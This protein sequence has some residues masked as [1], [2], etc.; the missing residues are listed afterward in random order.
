[1]SGVSRFVPAMHKT[2]HCG[3]QQVYETESSHERWW[4]QYGPEEEEFLVYRE[5]GE[6]MVSIRY[7]HQIRP[8]FEESS[9]R[10]RMEPGVRTI[11]L[12]AVWRDPRSQRSSY[13]NTVL[14]IDREQIFCG[15]MV[16]LGLA[17]Q[18]K[19]LFM[20]IIASEDDA[21]RA[22]A[23]A[24]FKTLRGF[25]Q[26]LQGDANWEIWSGA[27]RAA[28]ENSLQME[29]ILIAILMWAMYGWNVSRERLFRW[30][31]LGL[32]R[33]LR[34]DPEIRVNMLTPL[35][36]LFGVYLTKNE[37]DGLE[38]AFAQFDALEDFTNERILHIL[39]REILPELL[40][41][42]ASILASLESGR[43]RFYALREPIRLKDG[44]MVP[45]ERVLP[46]GLRVLH[47]ELTPDG[48]QIRLQVEE[49]NHYIP[50][51]FEI[52]RTGRIRVVVSGQPLP[53]TAVNHFGA[54]LLVRSFPRFPTNNRDF[55]GVRGVSLAG[56]KGDGRERPSALFPRPV[57][58]EGSTTIVKL[59]TII[60]DR[61]GYEVSSP[62]WDGGRIP[63]A[64]NDSD[65]IGCLFIKGIKN[66]S[67]QISV[68]ETTS[69]ASLQTRALASSF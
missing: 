7:H 17:R 65:R 37:E 30:V 43:P 19:T 27:M 44:S 61:K 57:A 50:V 38:R 52:P 6:E 26:E 5:R 32:H 68:E 62:E 56:G 58:L 12:R 69:L 42:C 45:E 60:M 33:A 20:M 8:C 18:A 35:V 47:G 21:E 13:L 4:E 1:M 54:G 23:K 49:S 64:H 11:L 25:I 53:A 14:P 67:L 28:V 31:E 40:P 48:D 9:T 10:M 22:R 24:W 29:D 36:L 59:A 66:I 41:H 51:G 63:H 34:R 55:L 46:H 2:R 15:G 39:L 16:A 3:K